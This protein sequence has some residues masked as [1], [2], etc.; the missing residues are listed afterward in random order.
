MNTAP[1]DNG[2]TGPPDPGEQADCYEAAFE[3]WSK[4]TTWMQGIFWWNWPVP[5]PGD[6]GYTPRNRLAEDVLRTWFSP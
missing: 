6:T 1:G 3:A 5:A 4:E 2:L